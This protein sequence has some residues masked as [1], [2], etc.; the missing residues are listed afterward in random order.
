[1]RSLQRENAIAGLDNEIAEIQIAQAQHKLANAKG[2]EEE[3]E[4]QVDIL[5]AEKQAIINDQKYE[6]T[7]D[8]VRQG[9]LKSRQTVS[10]A[11]K[12]L[13]NIP[14]PGGIWVPFWILMFLFFILIPVNGHTRLV[15]LWLV[16]T[17]NAKLPLLSGGGYTNNPEQTTPV[18]GQATGG[19]TG[20]S[21]TSSNQTSTSNISSNSLQNIGPATGLNINTNNIGYLDNLYGVL[22]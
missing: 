19:I 7:I 16:M 14:T 9:Y 20:G 18:L 2:V 11:N 22:I 4:A 21:T 1:M 5:G 15:W 12:R 3:R 17:N 10:H 6:D 13:A 8:K